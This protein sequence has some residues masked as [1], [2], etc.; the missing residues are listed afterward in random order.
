[1]QTAR[2]QTE[3]MS[4][5]MS[6]RAKCVTSEDDTCSRRIYLRASAAGE[7]CVIAWAVSLYCG[8]RYEKTMQNQEFTHE[9]VD[10][11]RA[12]LNAIN[13]LSRTHEKTASQGDQPKSFEWKNLRINRSESRFCEPK[14]R[15]S[16]PNYNGIKNLSKL[17]E[18]QTMQSIQSQTKA[19]SPKPEAR[20]YNLPSSSGLKEPIGS[21]REHLQTAA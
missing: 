15:S 8:I 7:Y 2:V 5:E 4:S 18:K 20:I 9:S 11:S 19:R 16:L 21:R 13:N 6:S 10:A 17:T 12:N 1:M 3:E 14:C